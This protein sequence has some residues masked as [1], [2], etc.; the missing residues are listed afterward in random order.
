MSG[1]EEKGMHLFLAEVRVSDEWVGGTKG[2]RNQII[3]W[4]IGVSASFK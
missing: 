2:S 3:V 1:S 4:T